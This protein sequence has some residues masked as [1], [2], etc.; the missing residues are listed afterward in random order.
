MSSV[1]EEASVQP[2]ATTWLSVLGLRWSRWCQDEGE[3][4]YEAQ[5]G[6]C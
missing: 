5:I 3:A 4:G 2:A 1:V 6:C